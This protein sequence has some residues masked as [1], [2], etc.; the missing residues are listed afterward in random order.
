MTTQVVQTPGLGSGG[1]FSLDLLYLLQGC[2]VTIRHL[3]LDELRPR[4]SGGADQQKGRHQQWPDL[5]PLVESRR[6]DRRST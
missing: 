1:V 5:H 4:I 6:S 2:R 3:Q